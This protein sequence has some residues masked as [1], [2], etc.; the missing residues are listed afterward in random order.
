MVFSNAFMIDSRN[1][2]QMPNEENK[3][4]R[5]LIDNSLR[6]KKIGDLHEEGYCWFMCKEQ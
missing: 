5:T 4:Q 6:E 1:R 3:Q 2:N